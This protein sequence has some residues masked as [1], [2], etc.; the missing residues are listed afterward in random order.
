MQIEHVFNDTVPCK[1]NAH[2]YNESFPFCLWTVND[3][4]DYTN[5]LNC[6]HD[7]DLSEGENV[8]RLLP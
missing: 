5:E 7:K 8:F 4:G 6:P 1:M 2:V 3:I